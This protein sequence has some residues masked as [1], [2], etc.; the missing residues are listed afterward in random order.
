MQTSYE[1]RGFPLI[2]L[3]VIGL[4]PVG[5]TICTVEKLSQQYGTE[6]NQ[7]SPKNQKDR[8]KGMIQWSNSQGVIVS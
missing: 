4:F 5:Q 8:V 6:R 7:S 1:V 2:S 3:E